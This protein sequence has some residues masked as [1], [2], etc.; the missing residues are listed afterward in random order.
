MTGKRSN[1]EDYFDQVPI[2]T[3]YW[4]S[5]PFQHNT[6]TSVYNDISANDKS[7]WLI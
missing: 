3:P 6:N 2:N 4:H 1:F 5:S 7:T